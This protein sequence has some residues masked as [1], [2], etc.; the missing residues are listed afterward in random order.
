[1]NGIVSVYELGAILTFVVFGM[2][3]QIMNERDPSWSDR[4]RLVGVA[5]I[6]AALWPVFLAYS[7]AVWSL[8]LVTRGWR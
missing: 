6:V 5:A 3:L 2:F 4:V 7:S 1:M 8:K